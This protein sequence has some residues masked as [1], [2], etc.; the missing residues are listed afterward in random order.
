[1]NNPEVESA[2]VFQPRVWM[3]WILATAG[4]WLLGSLVTY[5]LSIV[6]NMAGFGAIMEADPSQ[7]SQSTVLL[8]MGVSL[9]SL[10]VVGA[11]VG[12]LQWLVL[13][14]QV[15]RIQRWTLFTGLGFALGTFAF[16][17]LMGLGVG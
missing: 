12:A 13:R 15:P 4:G 2:A 11:A 1:M 7:V 8:L 9:V 10:L 3:W 14:W 16:W 6:L 5:G 17:V